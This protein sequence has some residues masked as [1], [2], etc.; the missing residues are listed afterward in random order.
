MNSFSNIVG[1][2]QMPQA[3]SDTARPFVLRKIGSSTTIAAKFAPQIGDADPEATDSLILG[4][5]ER[6]PKPGSTWSFEE[7]VRR[8]RTAHSIFDL[9]YSAGDNEQ[10]LVL[11]NAEQSDLLV[12]LSCVVMR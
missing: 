8:L 9:I 3:E 2:K 12:V 5:I 11:P 6:L 4:L 10:R 1:R 7:R